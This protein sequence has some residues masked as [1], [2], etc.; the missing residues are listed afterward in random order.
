MA[1][2]RRGTNSICRTYLRVTGSES[3]DWWKNRQD[4]TGVITFGIEVRDGRLTLDF[5]DPEGQR[6][7]LVD[8]QGVEI[9]RPW[10][11]SPVP[12]PYQIRGLGP[13]LLTVSNLSRIDTVLQ[14]VLNMRPVCEFP[15]STARSQRRAAGRRRRTPCCIPHSDF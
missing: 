9:A 8:D 2:G 3:L 4:R 6:L 11:R 15:G 1:G 12:E 5:E 10:E 13:I 14:K 7:S